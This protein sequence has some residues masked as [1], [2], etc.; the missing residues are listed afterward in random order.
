M[1]RLLPLAFL[2]G[3]LAAC[4]GLTGC[5]TNP[6]TH[7]REFVLM[8]EDQEVALGRRLHPQILEEMGRYPDAALQAY[9]RRV[10]ERLARVCD[11]PG[12]IY[13]FTVVDTD[14]VNA[15]ALPGGYIY[16]TRGLQD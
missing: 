1:R 14:D 8:S 5:A 15:F 12:L 16:I 9:V 2:A 4:A 3:M 11:R 13:R 10:G 7:Q 6:V